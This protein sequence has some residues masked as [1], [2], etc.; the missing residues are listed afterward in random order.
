MTIFHLNYGL[1]VAGIETMLVNIANVQVQM[2]H[3]VRILI[4]N[5]AI[6]PIIHHQ[7]DKRIKIVNF[8]KKKKSKNPIP[9]IRLN[10]YL[11][12]HRFD[13]LHMHN[14]RLS[15]MI[16]IP[17][18]QTRKCSTLHCLCKRELDSNY[19][20]NFR[21]NF[22]IS[23]AVRK[24]ILEKHNINATTV[25]NGIHPEQFS[26]NGEKLNKDGFFHIVQ[27]G[28]LNYPVKGQDIL[29]NAVGLLRKNG[30]TNIKIDFIGA[31]QSNCKKHLEDIIVHNDMT[32]VVNFLGVQSQ[33]YIAEHLCQYD[34]YA[35]PSRQEGFGL[36][37][38]EA[39]AAKVAT[40][41]SNV[42]GPMDVIDDGKYGYYFESENVEDCASVIRNIIINGINKELVDSAY[43]R[44]H[45]IFDV[46]QTAKQ[47][48]AQYE[49]I[50]KS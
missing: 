41:V 49:R 25:Y 16:Y 36:T 40:L 29:L 31:D 21:Y 18:A 17:I 1:L 28:R 38:A 39:M 8:G 33:Q 26:S 47:Y 45:T 22:A 43:Q 7:I 37:I 32:D 10:W 34:L 14:P 27:I 11:L 6:D 15:K 2:G 30:I 4:I 20:H 50:V 13:M 23:E 46:T 9:I 35:Q 19:L 3:D 44:V 24:D 42:P 12:T 48:L 5:D